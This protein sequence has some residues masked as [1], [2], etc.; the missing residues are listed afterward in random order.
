MGNNDAILALQ[1]AFEDESDLA[2]K[3]RIERAYSPLQST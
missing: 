1:A 3:R 2:V